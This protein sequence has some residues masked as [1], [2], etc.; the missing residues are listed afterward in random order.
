MRWF[1]HVTV[2]TIVERDGHFLM[3]EEDKGSGSVFNQPAG[4]L[5]NGESL[6]DAARRETLEETGWD[7]AIDELIGFYQWRNPGKDETYLRACFHATPLSH[8]PARPLDT[9]I[10]AAHWLTRDTL[11]SAQIRPRSPLVL[12]CI[13]DYLAGQRYPLALLHQLV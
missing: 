3:V 12:A 8:D 1:P 11:G 10:I 4:H 2:A 6:L 13:D 5:E 9:G 7:V